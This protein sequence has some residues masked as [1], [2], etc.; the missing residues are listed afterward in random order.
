MNLIDQ[1]V[2]DQA[3]ERVLASGIRVFNG[4][5]FGDTE[6]EHVAVLLEALDPPEGAMV[7]DAGCGVGEMARLMHEA[8]PDLQFLLVNTSE[9]QLA[10]CPEHFDRL[11]ADFHELPVLDGVADVVVF[12][13]AL[14]QSGDFP[15]VLR[16]AFRMLKPGGV[17]FINDMARLAGDNQL[18]EAELGAHAHTPEQ[19]EAWAA[20]AGFHLDFAIAPEVK[21]DRMRAL[22]G[23][24]GLADKLMGDIVPTI[25]RFQSFTGH[26]RAFHRHKGRVA[27][28]F[29]GGRDST[30]A[31]YALREFWPQMRVYHVDTGDQFPETRAVVAQVEKDLAEAGLELV[32][33]VT[34]VQG[35]HQYAGYPTDLVPVDNTVLGQMVSG[36]PLRLQG[37]YDCCAANL[38]NPLH[39]RMQLDGITLLIRGQRDDEY[40][41]PPLRS[42]DVS[43]GFEVLYP[44]QGWSAADVDMFIAE[45]GLPVAPFYEAGARRAP[46]CMSCTAWWDE[47]RAAYMRKHHP[48]EHKVFIQRMADIRREI[49]RSMSWLNHETE[50]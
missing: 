49:D 3:T 42:G 23:N 10:H 43:D 32:R 9:V 16:E 1:P 15:R 7:L 14:C 8:R 37:R 18:L 27:F 4:A 45:H 38:M 46:E 13:Y 41:A 40:A 47:G 20:D 48:N 25:W 22:I 50:A 29:S 34:D 33:I 39:A 11:H 31:L 5:L 26:Q 21:L 12:S 36:A 30:A 2:V 35:N 44:I 19:L 28:Q 17:L 24:D 6:A